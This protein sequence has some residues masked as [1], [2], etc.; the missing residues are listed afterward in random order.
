M[1]SAFQE[2]ARTHDGM[3]NLP[4]PTSG[5]RWRRP[6]SQPRVLLIDDCEMSGDCLSF[7]LSGRARDFRVEHVI[8][9]TDVPSFQPDVIL[10]ATKTASLS[11]PSVAAELKAIR[12]AYSNVSVI[13]V[14]PLNDIA[15]A[16]HAIRIGFQG[17]VPTT[18]PINVVIAAIR[19]VLA[20]SN[21]IPT[22][23]LAPSVGNSEKKHDLDDCEATREDDH[24]FTLRESEV[25]SRLREGKPNKIIA[26]ELSIAT[27]TVKVHLRSIMKKVHATNR[28]QVAL[29]TAQVAL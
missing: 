23:L 10:L 17:Y 16:L 12:H 25:L 26:Y 3:V 20:G 19:L 22:E 8:A 21:F 7:T 27:S 29:L 9:A 1:R 13:V 4:G 28:T 24:C 15:S 14:S 18:L 11:H 5:I 6:R 2:L